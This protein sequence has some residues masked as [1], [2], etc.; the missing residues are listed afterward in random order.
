MAIDIKRQES[1]IHG[2]LTYYE[3]VIPHRDIHYGNHK[4]KNIIP[5]LNR[6]LQKIKE[7][8]Y[9]ICD[10]C[11]E[12]IGEKRLQLIP[13]AIQCVICKKVEEKDKK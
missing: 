11:D 12:P 6:A 7:G 3:R 2:R 1:A 4:V 13:G 10:D 9:G 5:R 8:N